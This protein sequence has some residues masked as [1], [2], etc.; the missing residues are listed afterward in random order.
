MSS[1]FLKSHVAAE[2]VYNKRNLFWVTADSSV[3]E[4]LTSLRDCNCLSLP[5]W[6][7]SK[8]Q[9]IGIVNT[10]DVLAYLSFHGFDYQGVPSP[11]E[12][13][14]FELAHK[15]VSELI[16]VGEQIRSGVTLDGLNIM[17][18]DDT[19]ADVMDPFTVG[20]QRVLVRYEGQEE[21]P[22]SYRMLSQSDM[23]RFLYLNEEHLDQE[24]DKSIKELSVGTTKVHTVN[25]N[26][27]TLHAFREIYTDETC[28]AMAV[29]N[30]DGKLIATLSPSDIRAFDET[31]VASV[32]KPVGE[33]LKENNFGTLRWPVTVTQHSTLAQCMSKAV[34]GHL[35]R[36]W[37][38]DADEKP[39]GQVTLEDILHQFS[40]FPF[41]R[42]SMTDTKKLLKRAESGKA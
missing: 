26:D 20:V 3:K 28:E 1:Q 16:G 30:D 42:L 39:V 21:V 18:S 24:L 29:V 31:E 40:S 12:L 19:V 15:K 38:V 35:H 27:I 36:V 2:L 8:K 11:Q 13:T 33:F 6:D 41:R 34:L 23:V 37:I 17:E 25:I 4:A 32:L 9:F 10:F 14:A 22:S 5:V 7:E